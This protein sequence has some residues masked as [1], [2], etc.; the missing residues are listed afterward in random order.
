M[1][2]EKILSSSWNKDDNKKQIQPVFEPESHW[3]EA[4]ALT[5]ASSLLLSESH[6]SVV[7]RGPFLEGLDSRDLPKL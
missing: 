7:S 4:N 3:W 1:R 2:R 6:L 5:T